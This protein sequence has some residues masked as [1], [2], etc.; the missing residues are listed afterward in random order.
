MTADTDQIETSSNKRGLRGV[1]ILWIVLATIL[2]T[3]AITYWVV[4]TYIYAKDFTPVQLSSSE[5]QVLN[6][7]LRELV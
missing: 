2:V 7:K 6:V 5:Q 3:A 4:R 1:H